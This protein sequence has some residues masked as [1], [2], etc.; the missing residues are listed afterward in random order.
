MKSLSI[1]VQP[2]L[3]PGL[4]IA[5]LTQAF[6]SVAQKPDLVKH[7]AFDSGVDGGAYFNYTFGT[8]NARDLWI[9]IQDEIF[10]SQE[11]AY[12]M[13]RA[14]MVMCSGET[15]WDDYL[16]LFHFDPSVPID[17]NML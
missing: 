13:S 16:Q 1:Q 10:N 4:D 11:F 14:S 6:R 5:R 7:H 9:V 2:E 8:P 15:G 12:H 17:L 3:S